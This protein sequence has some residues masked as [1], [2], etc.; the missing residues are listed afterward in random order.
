M[1]VLEK[2]YFSKPKSYFCLVQQV[3]P[4]DIQ[5]YFIF[6]IKFED[7]YVTPLK[8]SKNNDMDDRPYN[9]NY[10][11]IFSYEKTYLFI[12][13]EPLCKLF[14]QIIQTILNVKK[15]NYLHN[16]TDFSCI[17]IKNKYKQFI[18]ENNEKVNFY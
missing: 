16:M 4:E 15:L 1:A 5:K 9:K 8:V 6:G 17:F 14:D 18:D 10:V 12:S 2:N 13:Y 7:F 3:S 11:N